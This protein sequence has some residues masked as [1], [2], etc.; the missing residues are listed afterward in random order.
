MMSSGNLNDGKAA[1]P[2]LK[3]IENLL[4]SFKIHYAILDAG[5]DYA[6]IYEH[7]HQMKSYSIIAYNK[8]NESELIGF[9]Q[10]FA[11]TCVRE[12]SYR[13]DSFDKKYQTL[14]YTRPKE[15]ADCPLAQDSLCQKVYKVKIETDL[16]RYSAPARGS[17]AWS[18]LYK[19]RTSVERVISYLKGFC[20][21]NNVRYRTGKRA[22]VHFDFATLVY[23]GMKLANLRL[24]QQKAQLNIAA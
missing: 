19:E 23:N 9:D 4:P 5:Y 2:L 14:K 10:H 24:Q 17:K 11:P 7:I 13:Y 3:G 21:L 12:H 20:Q 1:I 15:C 6:P 16:R 22:K 8:K 18:E